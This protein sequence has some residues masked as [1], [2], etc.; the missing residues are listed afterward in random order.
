[1]IYWPVIKKAI[2]EIDIM[3]RNGPSDRY[4]SNPLKHYAARH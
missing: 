4:L 3:Q 2:R 1:M